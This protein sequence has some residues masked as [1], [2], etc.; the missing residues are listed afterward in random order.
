MIMFSATISVRV[1]FAHPRFTREFVGD[2]HVDFCLCLSTATNIRASLPQATV[3]EIR[4]LLLFC[5]SIGPNHVGSDTEGSDT[6][7]GRGGPTSG[8]E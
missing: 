6:L 5:L 8:H 1:R 3:V 2:L 7:T 4:A